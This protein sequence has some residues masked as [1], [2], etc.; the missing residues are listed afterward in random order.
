MGNQYLDQ[1]LMRNAAIK[2]FTKQPIVVFPQSAYYT[3]DFFGKIALRQDKKVFSTHKNLHIFLREKNSYD[4]MCAH[5]PQCNFYCVPD[6]VLSLNEFTKQTRNSIFFC[7]RKDAERVLTEA[8]KDSLYQSFPNAEPLDTCC[9]ED[10]PAAVRTDAL[11]VFW[12]KISGAKLVVTDRLH[13]MIFCVITGTPCLVF[14]N[15]NHKITGTLQWLK[16]CENI[17]F[18]DSVDAVASIPPVQDTPAD[19]SAEFESLVSLLATLVKL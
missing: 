1:R 11:Q 12:Q 6:I 8:E 9:A 19:F 14:R 15:Y 5:F 7:L 17:V 16:N 3:K 2:T 18:Y 10:I 4:F 13:G